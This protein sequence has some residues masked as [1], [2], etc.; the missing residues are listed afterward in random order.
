MTRAI[1]KTEIFRK[2][3]DFGRAKTTQKKILLTIES[4][5]CVAAIRELGCGTSAVRGAGIV[6][7]SYLPGRVCCSVVSGALIEYLFP[8]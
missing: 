2:F 7:V 6:S 3:I 8:E 1:L 5:M 4:E